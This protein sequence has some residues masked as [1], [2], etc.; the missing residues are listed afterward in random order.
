MIP[1]WLLEIIDIVIPI[2]VTI[3]MVFP[4]CTNNSPWPSWVFCRV[5]ATSF[6][7]IVVCLCELC[8]TTIVHGHT[9]GISQFGCLIA[10]RHKLGLRGWCRPTESPIISDVCLTIFIRFC[11]HDDNTKTSTSTIDSR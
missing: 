11:C 10:I 5:I 6:Q 1:C 8:I 9:K 7:S 3:I 4:I 2:K